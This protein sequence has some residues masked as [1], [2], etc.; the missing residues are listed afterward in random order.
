M[1]V[2]ETAVRVDLE[3]GDLVG[4]G[5]TTYYK[6]LKE[7]ANYYAN[8][9]AAEGSEELAYYVTS[10]AHNGPQEVEEAL[11]WGHTCMYPLLVDGECCMTRGHFHQDLA[12]PE[13]YYCTAGEGYLLCWDGKDEVCAYHM[14]PGNLQYIDGRWAHRLI[15]TGEEMFKVAACW[16]TKAGN[17]YSS[18]ETKGFPVRCFK[19]AGKVEWIKVDE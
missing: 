5:L 15:N 18:I 8:P 2:Q 16:A 19:R 4:E 14:V 11:N 7:T 17:N 3:N 1:K 9:V 10:Q 6:T 12:Y 13:Y